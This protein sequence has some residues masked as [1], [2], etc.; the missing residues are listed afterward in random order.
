MTSSSWPS[1]RM[2]LKKATPSMRADDAADEQHRA[3]LEVQRAPPP[4]GDRAGHGGRRDLRGF[5]RDRDGRGDADE[6]Q[7]RRHQ[8]AAADAEHSRDKADGRPKPQDQ[9]DADRQFGYGQVDL[10]NAVPDPGCVSRVRDIDPS[11]AGARCTSRFVKA[12]HQA[13]HGLLRQRPI[14]PPCGF[15]AAASAMHRF[16]FAYPWVCRP[17]RRPSRRPG[18]ERRLR[19]CRMAWA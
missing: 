8:E 13:A 7:Q 5:G 19:Q 14:C 10:Q 12:L 1:R 3:E 4:I 6:D 17:R 18:Q 2:E 15:T 11:Q 16:S 9:E